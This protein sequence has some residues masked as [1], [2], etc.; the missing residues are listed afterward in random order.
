MRKFSLSVM[1]AGLTMLLVSSAEAGDLRK[2]PISVI[3][4]KPVLKQGRFWLAPETGTTVSDPLLMQFE[5]GAALTYFA[6]ERHAFSLRWEQFDLGPGLGGTTKAY[7]SS[8]DALKVVSDVAP[9]DWYAAAGYSYA[10][11]YG[12]VSLFGHYI[13][14][15]DV[16]T[17]AGLGAVHAYGETTPAVDLGTGARIFLNRYIGLDLNLRDRLQYREIASGEPA[18][19]QTLSLGLGVGIFLTPQPT[20]GAE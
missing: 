17:A 7:D 1:V 16:Y 10:P 14:Y 6:S 3:Q 2:A 12:K 5:L 4:D 13:G 19:V 15:Y 11:S 8:A 20:P 18:F 9:L